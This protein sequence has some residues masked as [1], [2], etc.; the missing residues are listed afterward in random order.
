[1]LYQSL[2]RAAVAGDVNLVLWRWQDADG[3][4]IRV[5]D[6]DRRLAGRT[7]GPSPPDAA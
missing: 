1:M 7:T 5:I 4:D 3:A 2:A 6:D